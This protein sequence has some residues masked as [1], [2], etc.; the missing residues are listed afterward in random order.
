MYD[1]IHYALYELHMSTILKISKKSKF[2]M[3]AVYCAIVDQII[4]IDGK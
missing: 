2:Y 1:C 3:I 4:L